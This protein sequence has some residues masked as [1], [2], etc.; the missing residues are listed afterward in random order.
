MLLESVAAC[1]LIYAIKACHMIGPYIRVGGTGING[2]IMQP[3][4]KLR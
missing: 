2:T 4:T 1:R 3:G